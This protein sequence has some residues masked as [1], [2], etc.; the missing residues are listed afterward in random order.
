MCQFPKIK[1][2]S[3]GNGFPENKPATLD[4]LD[5]S[6]PHS[7]LWLQ[8]IAGL[9]AARGVLYLPQSKEH[10]GLSTADSDR[11]GGK[12]GKKPLVFA[13]LNY[14][15]HENFKCQVNMY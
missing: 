12:S 8:P 13:L 7:C 15:G 3:R 10:M 11:G 2:G 4:R 14:G 5:T 6:H 9:H 1:N